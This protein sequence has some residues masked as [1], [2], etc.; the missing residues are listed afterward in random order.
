MIFEKNQYKTRNFL[1]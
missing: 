1:V